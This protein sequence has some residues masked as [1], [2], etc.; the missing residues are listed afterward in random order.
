MLDQHHLPPQWFATARLCGVFELV[1][2][3]S[4]HVL[5]A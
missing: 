3:F 4:A 1:A 2:T 5:L